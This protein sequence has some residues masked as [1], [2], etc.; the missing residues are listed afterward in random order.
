MEKKDSN[1]LNTWIC[2]IDRSIWFKQTRSWVPL[3][4][5]VESA[6]HQM[7]RE[8]AFAPLRA[9]TFNQYYCNNA[10]LFNVV[11]FILFFFRL[12][13]H[14]IIYSFASRF[15]FLLFHPGTESW[16]EKKRNNSQLNISLFSCAWLCL[17]RLN[18]TLYQWKTTKSVYI[19][20]YNRSIF[21]CTLIWYVLYNHPQI[22]C[23]STHRPGRIEPSL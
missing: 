13:I 16:A 4:I 3:T 11:R 7:S 15:Y 19:Y 17:I 8:F 21:V 1:S 9:L 6:L 5:T 10:N 14:F 20:K 22:T 23:W 12:Y 2:R 18:A